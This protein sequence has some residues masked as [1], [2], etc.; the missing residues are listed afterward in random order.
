MELDEFF[1]VNKPDYLKENQIYKFNNKNNYINY[2]I[3]RKDIVTFVV[4]FVV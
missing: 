1:R 4:D 2:L 3:K